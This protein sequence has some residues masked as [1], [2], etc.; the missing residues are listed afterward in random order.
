MPPAAAFAA[1]ADSASAFV[2]SRF[3]AATSGGGG[4]N[5]CD[6][7][8]GIC[9]KFQLG[10]TARVPASGSPNRGSYPGMAFPLI[11]CCVIHRQNPTHESDGIRQDA[12]YLLRHNANARPAFADEAIA[13]N[14]EP[15]PMSSN[16]LNVRLNAPV[17]H[18]EHRTHSAGRLQ[19]LPGRLVLHL[20]LLH[21]GIE[22]VLPGA[23]VIDALP[24]AGLIEIGELRAGY[25]LP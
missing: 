16:V 6:A 19:H 8:P 17:R 22:L 23:A 11:Q 7:M 25:L 1:A 2:A 5:H 9:A 15:A 13:V 10:C 12:R 18:H 4:A 3:S 24:H 20:L 21:A 14:P